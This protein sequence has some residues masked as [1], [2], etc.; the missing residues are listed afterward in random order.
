MN[1]SLIILQGNRSTK[2]TGESYF[3]YVK[4]PERSFE[5]LIL[6]RISR[7]L[8]PG[9][10]NTNVLSPAETF[11]DKNPTGS[12]LTRMLKELNKELVVGKEQRPAVK[13]E[14]S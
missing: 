5:A 7:P 11:T 12:R 9:T 10:M 4:T 3:L 2:E 6:K 13:G 14:H 1:H 8:H